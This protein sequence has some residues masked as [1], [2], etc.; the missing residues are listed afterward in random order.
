MDFKTLRR[1]QNLSLR[2]AAERI[3]I[4]YQ[5]ICRYENKNRVPINK[6]LLKMKKVYKCSE[7]EL[8]QAILNNIKEEVKYNER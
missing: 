4:S 5:S 1:R 6:I 7:T 8:G 2:E 3:G